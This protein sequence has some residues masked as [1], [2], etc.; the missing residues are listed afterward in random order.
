MRRD[1]NRKNP[2]SADH[3]LPRSA[4]LRGRNNFRRLFEQ[5]TVLN[6]GPVQF[7]YRIYEN[8]DENLLIGFAA[9]KRKIPKAARRNR[10]KR[11]LRE[12][13]RTR[14]SHLR[15]IV[16]D[17]RF[18]LHGLFLAQKPELSLS[19]TELHVKKILERLTSNVVRQAER[20]FGKQG[21]PATKDR[22]H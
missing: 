12:A 18:A 10:A 5:S 15:K 11:L 21:E 16:S 4:I 19:E 22:T 20:A 7:R 9:P 1:R 8:P 13:Y 2:S 6:S 3:S 14:Q 17:N